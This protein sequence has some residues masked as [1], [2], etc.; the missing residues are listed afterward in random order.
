MCYKYM[1]YSQS[2]FLPTGSHRKKSSSEQT[3]C[4]YTPDGKSP[5]LDRG[6][7]TMRSVCIHR[8]MYTTYTEKDINGVGRQAMHG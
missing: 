5:Y 7:R 8:R 6:E 3:I 1:G 4:I 2:F